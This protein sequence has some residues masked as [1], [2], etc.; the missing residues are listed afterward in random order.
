MI[1]VVSDKC[2]VY[3]ALSLAYFSSKCT[4]SKNAFISIFMLT[5]S[6][7]PQLLFQQSSKL[8]LSPTLACLVAEVMLLLFPFSAFLAL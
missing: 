5:S 4:V 8:P 2:Y 1:V 3:F 7:M 6:T